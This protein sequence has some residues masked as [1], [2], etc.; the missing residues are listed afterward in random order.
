MLNKYL[1]QLKNGKLE[2][3]IL[4]Q[5]LYFVLNERKSLNN[6]M[7]E[8]L[9]NVLARIELLN[10]AI[11]T[12]DKASAK[13]NLNNLIGMLNSMTLDFFN[14]LKQK[15]EIDLQLTNRYSLTEEETQKVFKGNEEE[16]NFLKEEIAKNT[17]KF[18]FDF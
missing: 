17:A 4:E 9:K 3:E 5:E 10:N 16:M 2:I 13:K 15:E 12:Q 11:L 14:V 1:E 7:V 6:E 8:F 18:N